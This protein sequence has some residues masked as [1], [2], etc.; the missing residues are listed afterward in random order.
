MS[1]SMFTQL[2]PFKDKYILSAILFH[3]GFRKALQVYD[4]TD[5]NFEKKEDEDLFLT[6]KVA[7][8]GYGMISN[9]YMWPFNLVRDI[10]S[11]EGHI[12]SYTTQKPKRAYVYI[13]T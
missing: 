4:A 5:Y 10:H 8:I 7:L 12:R 1:S 3:G 13:Y 2:C 9:I 11:L 6:T